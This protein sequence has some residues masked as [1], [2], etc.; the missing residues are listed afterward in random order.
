MQESP[1][2]LSAF[3]RDDDAGWDDAGLA[4]LAGLLTQ[5]AGVPM[6]L[7]AIPDGR[8]PTR[9]P[10]ELRARIDAAPGAGGVCTSTV[11]RTRQ[12]RAGGPASCE[13][14]SQ[15]AALAAQRDDLRQGRALLAGAASVRRVDAD[16]HAAVEPL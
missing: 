15:R 12:P 8:Q 16:V 2:P 14:G 5:R 7:A 13:F 4:R 6:D 11:M 1:A 3:V 9:W 10:R